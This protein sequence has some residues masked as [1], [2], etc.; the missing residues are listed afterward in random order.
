LVRIEIHYEGSLR[1]RSRHVPSSTLL[2]TDAPV[3]NQG[4]GQSFSP[5]DLLA[6]ALGT[7]MATTMGIL[8]RKQ[9]YDID[10]I[11]LHVDKHMTSSPPRRIERLDVVF[12]VPP[13]VAAK[14]DATAKQALSHSA[15]TCPVALSLHQ[16]VAVH[17]SFDW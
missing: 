7:C 10:G 11:A 13:Q 2:S 6:T 15:H 16:S 17:I 8:A 3:D 1:C 14:L 5:T 9:G 4:K 12:H